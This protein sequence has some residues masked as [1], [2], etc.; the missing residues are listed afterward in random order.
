MGGVRSMDRRARPLGPLCAYG[1]TAVRTAVPT[2]AGSGGGRPSPAAPAPPG[3]LPGHG[4]RGSHLKN[5][6]TSSV[7]TAVHA[8]TTQIEGSAAAHSPR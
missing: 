5:L 3:S 2:R 7:R 4:W 1:R 6:R 8:S